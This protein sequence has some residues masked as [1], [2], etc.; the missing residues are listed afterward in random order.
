MEKKIP[1][2]FPHLKKLRD[3]KLL[4]LTEL[5]PEKASNFPII[6]PMTKIVFNGMNKFRALWSCGCVFSEKLLLEMKTAKNSEKS[7]LICNKPYQEGDLVSLNLTNEE[8]EELKREILEKRNKNVII[9]KI[10]V[11]SFF[12]FFISFLFFK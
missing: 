9:V 11:C 1:R 3:L 2:N 4:N 12:F 6:C 7:C 10:F 8:Q 5:N